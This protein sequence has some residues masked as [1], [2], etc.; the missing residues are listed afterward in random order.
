MDCIFCKIAKKEI[1]T[2]IVYEEDGVIA[3]KDLHPI[4]PV[5]ILIIPKKHIASIM[6][7]EDNDQKLMG[8]LIVAAK[9]I[10][11]KCSIA[12]DGYKL[13]FRVG[14]FGGQEIQHVH[15]HL[16][17]GAMLEENIRPMQK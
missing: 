14:K 5:H 6:D 10:A 15:L 11:E 13:L 4:A 7:I 9:Q 8:A 3:F 12:K 1:K 2:K 16:L 17:G